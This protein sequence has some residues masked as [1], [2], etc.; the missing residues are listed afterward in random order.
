MVLSCK[1]ALKASDNLSAIHT[2][3]R[4]FDS[5]HNP[6]FKLMGCFCLL[7]SL[8]RCTQAGV[9]EISS[10]TAGIAPSSWAQSQEHPLPF[11][12]SPQN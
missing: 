1:A 4:H 7:L 3:K 5:C 6:I 10:I 12:W 8:E 11:A 9:A 2:R